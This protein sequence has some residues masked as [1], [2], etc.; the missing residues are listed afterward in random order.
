MIMTQSLRFQFHE[1]NRFVLFLLYWQVYVR[2]GNLFLFRN[3]F[4]LTVCACVCVCVC[5]PHREYEST[6]RGKGWISAWMPS[7]PLLSVL[8][9]SSSSSLPD[10]HFGVIY[11]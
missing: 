4:E 7:R 11:L 6:L 5:C 1:L 10:T 9:L 2:T 8:T 3:S